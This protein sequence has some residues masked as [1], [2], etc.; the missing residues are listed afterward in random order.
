MKGHIFRIAHL[1]YFDVVD[2][3]GI[4]AQLELILDTNGFPVKLG[5]GVAAVQRY[6]AESVAENQRPVTAVL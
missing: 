3:F 6:Y 2:L 4:I 5:S 1:G